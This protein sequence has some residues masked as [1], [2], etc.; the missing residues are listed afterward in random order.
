MQ[1]RPWEDNHLVRK[2]RSPTVRKHR[3][4]PASAR[5]VTAIT[6]LAETTSPQRRPLA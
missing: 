1:A 4:G 2:I 3:I 6:T 5:R